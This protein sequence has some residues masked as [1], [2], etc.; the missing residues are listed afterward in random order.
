MRRFAGSL[1]VALLLVACT[2][3]S[4]GDGG[5]KDGG[6]NGTVVPSPDAGP[7]DGGEDGGDGG[8][9]GPVGLCGEVTCDPRDL[10]ACGESAACVL[11]TAVPACGE[12]GT[13]EKG[14]ACTQVADCVAGLAC[15]KR[16]GAGECGEV[17]CAEDAAC[18]GEGE[19]CSD[20]AT[21]VDGA[22]TAW[23][24][25]I[26]P[27]P[28]NVLDSSEECDEGE[29]CYVVS[30]SAGTDCLPEGAKAIDETCG[31]W[32][33]CAPGLVCTGTGIRTCK[34]VC[35]IGSDDVPCPGDSQHCIAYA[36]SPAGT[37]VCTPK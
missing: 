19:R 7:L 32:N 22:L 27:R 5:A 28:C 21:L 24:R 3:K 26:P 8:D 12:P 35:S 30:A 10:A 9:A 1:C 16:N 14:E 20:G 37:G 13:A 23:G 4:D 33:D 6:P 17:C 11:A 29:G 36:Y 15:F 18:P 2:K 25:C 34:R 31:G